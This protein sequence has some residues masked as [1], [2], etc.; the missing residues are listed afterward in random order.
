MIPYHLYSKSPPLPYQ[1]RALT[2]GA[3][4]R[5]FAY[6]YPPGMGKT[7]TALA[8]AAHL[9]RSGLID[10]L[11]VTAPDG[12]HTQWV[13][14]Q[15]PAFWPDDLPYTA[16]CW[17]S[18]YYTQGSR[19]YAKLMTELLAPGGFRVFTLNVDA[20]RLPRIVTLLRNV[21]PLRK[22][23]MVSDES[24]DIKG[25]TAL[26]AI[27]AR[28]M[29]KMAW[30]LR[31]LSATPMERPFDLYG[32]FLFLDPSI[33]GCATYKQLKMRYADWERVQLYTE[34]GEEPKFY[35]K[36]IQYKDLDKLAAK[37]APF[38][39]RVHPD[40]SGL[41]ALTFK[42]WRF[43][44]PPKL[45]AMHDQLEEEKLVVHENVD[46]AADLPIVRNLRQQQVTC[47]Y[48]PVPLGEVRKVDGE[49]SAEP[50]MFL[51][52][53]KARTDALVA[54]LKHYGEL[55]SLIFHRFT[56]DAMLIAEALERAG[57]TCAIYAGPAAMR[58]S[59]KQR[60]LAGHVQHLICNAAIVQ[61]VDGLQAADYAVHY[62]T[63]YELTK[64]VQANY[65]IQRVGGTGGKLI[66]ELVATRTVD[67]KLRHSR[68]VKTSYIDPI[69][70]AVEQASHG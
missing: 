42:E 8:N 41:P 56:P 60:F 28:R 62:S 23:M 22:Y 47:G 35:D 34:E 38:S 18:G 45:Q 26:R 3:R 15:L 54:C 59:A 43:T 4:Q 52:E 14:D 58:A 25:L 70:A 19:R 67:E 48:L 57:I 68:E 66:V 21:M 36:L 44:L 10:G 31:I 51:P 16:H 55:R 5:K 32:Q 27:R 64:F 12:V 53:G 37:I 7:Y 20:F 69:L 63:Y 61:G 29:A 65:R 2:R 33:I 13:E 30:Y 9:H 11:I 24:T 17:D 6:L 46:I 1:R 40:E 50:T 49:I 39:F